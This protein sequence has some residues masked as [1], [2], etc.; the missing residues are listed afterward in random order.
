MADL[1]PEEMEAMQAQAGQDK[2]GQV[3]KLAQ[4]VGQ[5]LSQLSQIL[6][7]SQ[8]TTD[9]DKQQMGQIMSLYI[10][11]VEKKLGGSAP[12]EDAPEEAKP[13]MNQVPMQAGR[14]GV[15][16]GPQTRS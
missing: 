16:V 6:D 15:P 9:Q 2:V 12:G 13:E 11:L 7:G 3:T 8:G 5:G 14:G 4:Q 1:K 10:D